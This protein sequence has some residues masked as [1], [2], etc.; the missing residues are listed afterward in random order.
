MP[1]DVEML[2]RVVTAACLVAFCFCLGCGPNS[3]DK[4]PN[5]NLPYSKEGPPKRG[6][7]PEAKD[8]KKG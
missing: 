8:S 3:K 2:R 4:D 1:E 7:V 5:P 6:G